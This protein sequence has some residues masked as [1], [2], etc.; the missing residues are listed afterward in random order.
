MFIKTATTTPLAVEHVPLDALRSDS[1]NPRHIS[2]S[3]LEALTTLG[4]HRQGVDV[5]EA[6]MREHDR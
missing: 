5:V 6:W 1:A 2:A 3:E 4:E